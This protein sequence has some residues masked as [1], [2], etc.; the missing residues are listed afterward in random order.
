MRKRKLIKGKLLEN[1]D[2][3]KLSFRPKEK[4]MVVIVC[5]SSKISQNWNNEQ[6]FLEFPTL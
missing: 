5:F 3:S 2:N 4:R 6:E 1:G